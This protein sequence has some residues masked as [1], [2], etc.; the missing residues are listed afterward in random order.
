MST[1]TLTQPI[2]AQR[3]FRESVSAFL[4]AVGT[5]Y[6]AYCDRHSRRDQIDALHALSDAELAAKGIKRDEIARYVFRDLFYI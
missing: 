6:A 1:T 3:S 4:T 5:G 2:P